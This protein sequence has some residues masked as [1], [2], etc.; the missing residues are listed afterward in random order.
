MLSSLT[1]SL[2]AHCICAHSQH[3][4]QKA[5]HHD[6]PLPC[7]GQSLRSEAKVPARALGSDEYYE[8]TKAQTEAKLRLIVEANTNVEDAW[9]CVE[10]AKDVGDF[11]TDDAIAFQLLAQ[12]SGRNEIEEYW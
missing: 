7:D 1:G 11:Y 6:T 12:L 3:R 10:L 4:T 9:D 5:R 2:W 8:V